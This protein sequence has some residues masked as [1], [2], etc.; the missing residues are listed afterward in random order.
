MGSKIQCFFIRPSLVAE[1]SFRR[2]S[3]HPEDRKDCPLTGNTMHSASKIVGRVPWG[4]NNG[5]VGADPEEC[6]KR[7]PRWPTHC[8]CGYEFKPTDYWQ[9]NFN[10]MYRS[11]AGSGDDLWVLSQ[12]PAGAM[13]NADW[14]SDQWKGP[15]GLCLIVKTPGGD[16]MIDAPSSQGPGWRREGTPPRITVRPS[17]L[18]PTYHGWLNDGVLEEC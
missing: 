17:I 8:E 1:E 16:W 11:C 4:L 15:D 7:D 13:W 14:M 12:A 2:F 6:V 3:I 10:V 18:L 9:H 5:G